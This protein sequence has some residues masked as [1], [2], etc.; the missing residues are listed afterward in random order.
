MVQPDSLKAAARQNAELIAKLQAER[1]ALV[2]TQTSLAAQVAA[3]EKQIADL[4]AANAK[5]DSEIAAAASHVPRRPIR[6]PR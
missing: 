3:A 1:A 5:L 4:N 6:L 2:T